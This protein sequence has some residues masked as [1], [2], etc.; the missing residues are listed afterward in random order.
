MVPRRAFNSSGEKEPGAAVEA[1]TPGTAA[2]CDASAAGVRK[3]GTNR[4]ARRRID[5]ITDR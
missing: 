5:A 2:P 3:I 4:M 1:I